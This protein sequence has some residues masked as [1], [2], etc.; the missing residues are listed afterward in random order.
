MLKSDRLVSAVV[1][2]VCTVGAVFSMFALVASPAQAEQKCTYVNFVLTCTEVTT[3]GTPGHP[4]GGGD[5]APPTCDLD[6]FGPSEYD[7]HA[8]PNFCDGSVVCF[9]ADL[10]PPIALPAGDPPNEDSVPRG[11]HCLI[12]GADR[13]VRTFWSDDEEPPTLLQQVLTAIDALDFTTPTVGISPP[14]RTLVNL[15]TWFW[16]QGLQPTVS[17][18]AFTV[19]ATATLKSMTVDPGDGSAPFGCDPVATDAAQA[20]QSCLH[21][22]RRSSSATGSTSIDGHRAFQATVTTV[23]DLSFSAGGS[24]IPQLAGAP[25]T[26]D[27]PPSTTAVRVEEAQTVVRPA[28]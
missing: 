14:A 24:P 12:G 11:T 1:A 4:G 21:E 3:G 9:T 19:T 26:V 2:S 17:A 27:G 28:R 23:Y 13:V 7:K 16:L 18:T 5:D 15:D 6:S 8:T 20:E 25:T 22:Y 10:L